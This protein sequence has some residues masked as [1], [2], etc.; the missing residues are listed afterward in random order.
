M[1]LEWSET[2]VK[3]LIKQGVRHFCIAYGNRST[4]LVL[5]CAH[6]PLAKTYT[7]FD[8]RGLGY[9]ALGIAK[10]LDEPVA[11][12]V[13]SGTAV[14]NLMPA[15]MEASHQLIPLI[16]LTAD[17]P[18]ELR[19]SFANQTCD[20]H[21]IFG[22]YP[23]FFFDL[24]TPDAK[25]SN[26]FLQSVVAHAVH[27]TLYPV[28]GPVHINCPF[29]E[30]FFDDDQAL[31]SIPFSTQYITAE[32]NLRNEDLTF[33]FE[34]IDLYEE[35][36]ILVG[37][38]HGPVDI[39]VL[40]LLSRHLNF[41]ILSEIHSLSRIEAIDAILPYPI[42]T[43]KHAKLLKCPLPKVI[44]LLGNHFIAKEILEL[45][46]ADE[47]ECVVQVCSHPHQADPAHA[48]NFHIVGSME[49]FCQKGVSALEKKEFSHFFQKWNLA[50]KKVSEAVDRMAE[51]TKTMSEPL[52]VL[53]LNDLLQKDTHLF[54]GN[55]LPIRYMND[56]FQNHG[57][58]LKI[59]TNRGLSGID[60]NIA[61][62]AGLASAAEA[63][64]IAMI[65][66]Q[67]ALHDLNSLF[68]IDKKKPL[69]VLVIN[70][71]GGAIFRKVQPHLTQEI[72][73]KFFIGK[74]AYEFSAICQAAHLPY[75]Q[76]D[77]LDGLSFALNQFFD[78]KQAMVIEVSL[79]SAANEEFLTQFELALIAT[80]QPSAP[81][82]SY[83]FR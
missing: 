73:D 32:P 82:R 19:E 2:L 65:G 51:T 53:L 49:D 20:Q 31:P 71:Y 3:E 67:T 48:V 11:V 45:I 77:S 57:Q 41:P 69:L 34:Q 18:A 14:G 66:D 60:G 59:F 1:N 44:I 9:F 35:G 37:N 63:N 70:N 62:A 75:I 6:H 55:S 15:V 81:S 12:I 40:T 22:T 8:E 10:A 30:P 17:R 61:T 24:P 46:V 13:T 83:F 56:F 52:M 27:K 43:L 68:L 78:Q 76:V 29:R 25:L 58:R 23:R 33:L 7:H 39:G 72:L 28:K 16:I 4:P 21:R 74:H 50:A 5:S 64:V 36:M 47:V 79:D 26:R 42:L 80:T 54:V 38:T